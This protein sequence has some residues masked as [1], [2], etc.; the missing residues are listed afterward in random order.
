MLKLPLVTAL[1]ASLILALP[2]LAARPAKDSRYRGETSQKR[3]I[4]ARVTSDRTG[5]QLEFNQVFRCSKGPTK[6]THSTYRRQRPTIRRDGTFTYFKTYRDLGPIPGF[7]EVHTERQ[8][9][10]G[11][12]TDGGRRVKGR[13]ASSVVGTSSGLRCK[14]VVTFSARRF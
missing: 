13:V 1:A 7:D 3:K 12:F 5:L 4:S 8:R 14:S 11:A 9:V 10:T 2:A 6:T